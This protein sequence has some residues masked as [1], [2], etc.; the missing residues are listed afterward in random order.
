MSINK[1]PFPEP[2]PVDKNDYIAQNNLIAAGLLDI[3][4]IYP[5]DFDNDEIPEG[6]TFSIGGSLY[7]VTSAAEPITGTPSKY[8]KVTK[9]GDTLTATAAYVADLTGVAWNSVYN[10]YADGSGNLYLFD[11]GRGVIDGDIT[12]P[13]TR[14]GASKWI[15]LTILQADEIKSPSGNPLIINKTGADP[16]LIGTS[17][18]NLT[19]E[20]LQVEG[21]AG[22]G[23]AI[24]IR[25]NTPKI[26][27]TE[28]DVVKSYSWR[29]SG[30]NLILRD[31]AAAADRVTYQSGGN[32]VFSGGINPNPLIDSAGTITGGTIYSQIIPYIPTIGDEIEKPGIIAVAQGL[33]DDDKKYIH[34]T[35][36]ERNTSSSIL[37]HG[38]SYQFTNGILISSNPSDTLS[39]GSASST[40]YDIRV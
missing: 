6:V 11:E 17:T 32:V 2:E 26:I 37:F 22:F 10:H 16:V 3:N 33:N 21:Q 28:E 4:E 34:F 9:S 27:I 39:V 23:D 35:K 30:G 25:G 40:L 20:I 36:I 19:P 12:N 8:V 7:K 24:T 14:F 18:D 29:G 5:I 38:F 31:E 15:S 13:K 1:I